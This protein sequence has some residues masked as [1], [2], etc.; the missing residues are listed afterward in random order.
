MPGKILGLDITKDWVTAVQ[1]M[2]GMKGYQV[3]A[4][5]EAA[6][7]ED[8]GLEGALDGISQQMELK[9]D[10]CII[11]IPGSDVSYRNLQ[12]PFL[13]PKKI[14]QTLPFEM[15][16]I[17]PFPIEEVVVDF[18][19]AG[20]TDQSDVLAVSL[21]K[22]CISEYLATLNGYGLDPDIVDIQC[23]P[24]VTWLLSQEGIPVNGLFMEIDG[25]KNT[26]IL[27]LQ[28]R[29]A[30]IRTLTS[31]GH[32]PGQSTDTESMGDHEPL[33]VEQKEASLQSLCRIVKNTVH[34]FGWQRNQDIQLD[35][36]FFLETEATDSNTS[37]YL[38]RFLG[39]PVERVN[40][41][42]DKRIRMEDHVIRV[43]DP[44]RMDRALALALRDTKKGRGFNF[45]KGE[46]E[47]TKRFVGLKKDIRKIGISL[48][49]I[50]FFLIINLGVD[51]HLLNKQYE[52]A[53]QKNIDLYSQAFPSEKNV[54]N[55]EALI[56]QKLS[57]LK[58]SSG[59]QPV[60]IAN[61]KVIDLLRDISERIPKELD[62]KISNMVIDQTTA[63]ISGE[64]D[65]FNTVDSIKNGLDASDFFS[66]VTI[67]SSK[68]DR[69]GK[70]VQ[71][72]IKLQRK[73]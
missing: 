11:S 29:I 42:K 73:I 31:N 20:Q 51:Y 60:I 61:Q 9:S 52:F 50:L 19:I 25:N 15:E 40:L 71:F 56:N 58:D 48:G 72:E 34:S 27:Y 5:A 41:R 67:S 33:I 57:Q 26:M 38:N 54:R 39:A 70:R 43:C 36:V 47:V 18:N 59:S 16:T 24:A 45:R 28:K 35:M 12:M 32:V 13:D 65:N 22:N 14:K 21:K 69:T 2:S 3:I 37:E 64:T 49:L 17:V 30:L 55:P 53:T 23:V 1:V 8:L 44:A 10:T 66:D 46:F 68:K 4:C 7:V 6:I 63:R 62:I